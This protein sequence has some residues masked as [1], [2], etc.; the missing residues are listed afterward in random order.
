MRIRA[1]QWKDGGPKFVYLSTDASLQRG[2]D[3]QMSLEDMIS[4]SQAAAFFSEDFDASVFSSMHHLVSTTLPCTLIGSGNSSLSG[5]Y[6]AVCDSIKLDIGLDNMQKYGL[7]VL[8][9]VSD[10]GVEAKFLE[11]PTV[12]TGEMA[13]RAV[14][15]SQ[16]QAGLVCGLGP[17]RGHESGLSCAESISIKVLKS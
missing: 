4:Q 1:S 14:E 5:K 12:N 7:S 9:F 13:R 6:E 16:G 10:Y 11:V 8:S 15:N 17:G 2:Q 3:Y